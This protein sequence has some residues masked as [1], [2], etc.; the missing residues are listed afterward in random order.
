MAK[1]NWNANPPTPSEAGEVNQGRGSV[2]DFKYDA[3]RRKKGKVGNPSS[4]PNVT[5]PSMVT[6]DK[7]PAQ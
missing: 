7:R 6:P 1:G 4:M 3:S 5:D 2:T